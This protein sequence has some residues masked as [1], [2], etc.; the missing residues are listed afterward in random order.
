MCR[1]LPPNDNNAKKLC[2][3]RHSSTLLTSYLPPFSRRPLSSGQVGQVAPGPWAAS[4]AVCACLRFTTCW[5]IDAPLCV[6]YMYGIRL[7]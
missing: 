1:L 6:P 3:A 2:Q 5:I 7:L 4:R